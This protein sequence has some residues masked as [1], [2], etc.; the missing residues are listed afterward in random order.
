[1]SQ[2]PM[3]QDALNERE[4]EIVSLISEGLSNKEIANQLFLA[5]STVK[6]YVHELNSKLDT[7]DRGEIV[8]RA[9]ELGLLEIEAPADTYLRPRENLPRQTTSFVGRDT[10]LDELHA[11]LEKSD[12]RLLTILAPG[13]MGK[14]RIALEAAEKQ[15]NNFPDGVYFVPLQDL[16]DI[17]QIVPTVA[18]SSF[19]SFQA[20]KRS[21]K[22]QLLNFLANKQMLLFTDTWE[23]LLDGVQ[24]LNE[25]LNA[26][27]KVKILATSREKLNLMG[28]TVY[29]LQ[30]ME[31][32]TWETLDYALR[33]DAVQLLAQAAQRVKLDWEV[34]HDNLGYVLRVCRL[35][36]G[37]PL[38]ILLAMTWLDMLSIQEIATEIEKN[39]D[40][41]ETEMRDMPE[42]QQSIRA[43]FNTAWNTLNKIQ[44]DVFMKLTVFRGGFSRDAAEYVTGANLRVLQALLNKALLQV[45]KDGRYG[46]HELLR[47]YGEIQLEQTGLDDEAHDQHCDYYLTALAKREPDLLGRN[48]IAALNDIDTEFEN[49]RAAWHR[50]MSQRNAGPVDNALES[51]RMFC[52]YRNRIR[53]GMPL[54]EQAT[55]IFASPEHEQLWGRVM[56]RKV[57]LQVVIGVATDV[58]TRKQLDRALVIAQKHSNEVEIAFCRVTIGKVMAKDFDWE[59]A[60]PYLEDG[61]LRYE[62]FENYNMQASILLDLAMCYGFMGDIPR[63]VQLLRRAMELAQA[64]GDLFH[65][66]GALGNLAWN[67]LFF[68]GQFPGNELQAEVL[69][70]ESILISEQ[71]GNH[72]GV[73][74]TQTLLG[75][76][77]FFQGDFRKSLELAN[78]AL[79]TALELNIPNTVGYALGCK[80]LAYV[81]MENYEADESDAEAVSIARPNAGGQY[82][83]AMATALNLM[84]LNNYEEAKPHCWEV[85]HICVDM[86]DQSIESIHILP[87]F[88]MLISQRGNHQRAAEIHGLAYTHP[89]SY[90]EWQ[91]IVPLL[92]RFRETLKTELGDQEHQTA[93]ERGKSLDI[94]I[95]AG[96][97]LEEF[98]EEH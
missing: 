4:L 24:L 56:T 63:F 77:A 41:L 29:V 49:V 69:A 14:T 93:F 52:T 61:L 96:E 9:N 84:A 67:S 65:V 42:R 6:W 95:V 15:I 87:A 44:Q 33:Y 28:E 54:L 26:A 59:K 76:L 13:G 70:Q 78:T 18:S 16:S 10:G 90:Q 17:E 39:V 12:V 7:K 83:V 98:G 19:F 48:Q 53:V 46:I 23:H 91:D 80:S 66:D 1:M 75:L 89:S 88:A 37:M 57:I 68:N 40:F 94:E 47:Q 58:D 38:G 25:I 27:P 5:I 50:A 73:C 31:S 55:S 92:V 60:L 79:Q 2:K 86:W 97:L 82:F 3:L 22:Q 11:I 62:Q 74:H 43:I 8:E 64:N 85:L 51:L 30:G 35:T 32:P 71:L 72:G 20:G 21:T 45:N 34:T 81:G 36:Q